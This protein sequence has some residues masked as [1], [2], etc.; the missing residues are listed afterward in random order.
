VQRFWWISSIIRLQTQLVS[1][2]DKLRINLPAPEARNVI[3]NKETT[4]FVHPL[5]PTPRDIQEDPKPYNEVYR[6]HPD[7]IHHV[8]KGTLRLSS[9]EEW[10]SEPNQQPVVLKEEGEFLRKSRKERKA[11]N[12]LRGYFKSQ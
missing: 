3:P 9:E 2:I 7:R 12:M 6:V 10:D 8:N 4:A 5:S 1:Y 11:F